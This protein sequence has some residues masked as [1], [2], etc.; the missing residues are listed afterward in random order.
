MNKFLI[1]RFLVGLDK[2]KI[3]ESFF[4]DKLN[5]EIQ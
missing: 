2:N 5:N 4:L 1:Y 3:I